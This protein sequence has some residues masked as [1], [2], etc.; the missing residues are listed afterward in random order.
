MRKVVLLVLMAG[1]SFSCSESERI[2][3]DI[4]PPQKMG[5]VLAD[6]SLA[7]AWVENYFP[8][9]AN[10]PRD[11]AISRE[12]DKVLAIHSVGQA[13]FRRS[14]QYYKDHP[15][16]F[17][18]MLD[19]AFHKN[20]NFQQRTFNAGRGAAPAARDTARPRTRPFPA[21]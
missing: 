3:A 14:Y 17:R 13:D 16:Q 10:G 12:V 1:M 9:K 8:S 5:D 18:D 4:L 6:I 2:P 21:Q 11:S 20:Q 15:I 7:E 19:S